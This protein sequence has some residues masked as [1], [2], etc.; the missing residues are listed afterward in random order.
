MV[1][2]GFRGS[3]RRLFPLNYKIC[4]LTKK[5]RALIERNFLSKTSGVNKTVHFLN[6][7]DDNK[8]VDSFD[9]KMIFTSSDNTPINPMVQLLK[10][11]GCLPVNQ[12]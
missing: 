12:R 3:I 10:L 1:R 9:N 4:V 11:F 6:E 8:P 5:I 7:K 2:E